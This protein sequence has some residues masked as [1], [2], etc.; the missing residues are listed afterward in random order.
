[1]TVWALHDDRDPSPS[2]TWTIR[3]MVLFGGFF[4][5]NFF[6]LH[7]LQLLPIIFTQ[8]NLCCIC[9]F[10][11][12]CSQNLDWKLDLPWFSYIYHKNMFVD[13]FTYIHTY[14]SS[15]IVFIVECIAE[16]YTG[17]PWV[18]IGSTL[19][20]QWTPNVGHWCRVAIDICK[21][22]SMMFSHWS[23]VNHVPIKIQ[24]PIKKTRRFA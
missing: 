18:P 1:M 4:K 9:K 19:G 6:T 8:Q 24:G 11:T 22:V 21:C 10:V 3:Y 13:Y 16:P 2:C 5:I 12:K 14:M 20:T 23:S 7:V 15:P 17:F